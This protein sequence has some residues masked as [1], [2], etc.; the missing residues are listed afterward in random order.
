M[1]FMTFSED[2][3]DQVDRNQNR[4]GQVDQDKEAE[5]DLVDQD[6][7][8]LEDQDRE[9]KDQGDAEA[10]GDKNK[11]WSHSYKSTYLYTPCISTQ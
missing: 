6:K 8:G 4:E 3:E 1:A 9:D 5:E 11:P 2:K 7:E 10:G